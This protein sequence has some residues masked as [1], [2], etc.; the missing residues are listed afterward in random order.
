MGDLQNF[1]Y[2]T[3]L[4]KREVEVEEIPTCSITDSMKE[5]RR[6]KNPRIGEEIHY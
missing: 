2:V 3:L 1:G 6:R 4:T 5:T